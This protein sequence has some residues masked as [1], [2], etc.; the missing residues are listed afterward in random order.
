MKAREAALKDDPRTAIEEYSKALAATPRDPHCLLSRAL[1][2]LKLGD[3]VMLE[4]ALL[5]A[6][7][8]VEITPN[9][10][11]TGAAPPAV[12]S[13]RGPLPITGHTLTVI[14][15]HRNPNAVADSRMAI[16]YYIILYII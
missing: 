1:A 6:E 15:M 2:V 3:K 7:T 12:M 11:V 16:Y 5:D 8:V 9:S 13:V 10:C 4:G 14:Y